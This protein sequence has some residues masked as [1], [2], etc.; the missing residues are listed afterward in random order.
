MY[1]DF[2]SAFLLIQ[3]IQRLSL[4]AFTAVVIVFLFLIVKRQ[5]AWVASYILLKDEPKTWPDIEE[6]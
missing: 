5:K 6:H 2:L 1:A 4:N 3:L